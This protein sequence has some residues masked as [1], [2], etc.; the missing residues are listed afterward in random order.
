[1]CGIVGLYNFPAEPNML[2]RMLH[3]IAHRGPDA[4]GIPNR[5]ATVPMSVW[6]IAGCQS[7]ICRTRPTSR[8]R[9]MD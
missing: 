7:S 4:E 3:S 6:G 9:R 8:S 2:A 5:R 1:M